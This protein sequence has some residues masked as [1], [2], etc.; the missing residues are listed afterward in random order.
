MKAN[1]GL[2]VYMLQLKDVSMLM[3]CQ[4]HL[5]QGFDNSS[6]TSSFNKF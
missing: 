1:K 6:P 5:K 4:L 2:N 3:S